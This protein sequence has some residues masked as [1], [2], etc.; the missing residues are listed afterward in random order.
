MATQD[1]P[2]MTT[3]Q[4]A[5]LL[6][7]SRITVYRLSECGLLPAQKVGGQWR[8]SRHAIDAWMNTPQGRPPITPVFVEVG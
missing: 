6:Q 5:E 7:I 4:V 1:P 2:Y 3:T 8:F